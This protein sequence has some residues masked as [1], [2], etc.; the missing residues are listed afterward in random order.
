MEGRSTTRTTL[1]R[2]RPAGWDRAPAVPRHPRPGD[3]PRPRTGLR[4]GRVERPGRRLRR[5]LRIALVVASALV[6]ALTGTAW[7]LYRDVTAGISTTDVI[8]GGGDGGD[9][10]ILLVGVDS[11]TDAHGNPLPPEV[12][13]MLSSGPDTGVLNSDTIILLHVP[14]GG[15]A[16][17]AFSIPR[18]AYV[19]IPG[20]RRDKINAA[21]PATKAL[22]AERLV[23][24]GVKD[25][26]QIETESAQEG[27]STL[28]RTVENLTGQSVDHYAEINLL[29][30]YNLTT[31]IGGVDVCLRDPV[32]DPLSGARFPAGPQTISGTDALAFVRQRHGL[33]EGDLSRIRRQQVFLAAVADKILA[34]GTLSDPARLGTL[35]EVAQ[36]SLVIDA[37]WDL[38]GFA[39]QAADIAAGNLQ[40]VTIP[41]DG[42][43]S[44]ARGDVVLVDPRTVEE[45]IER[46][47]GEQAAAAEAA[48]QAA[49]QAAEARAALPPP[50]PADLI[51]SRYVVD[52]QNGSALGGMAAS[53]ADHLRG[54]GFARGIVDNTEATD[55]SVVRYTGP[56]AE[57]ARVVAEQLG[58][59]ST[60]HDGSVARGHLNVVLGSDFDP[61]VVPA[62]A[63]EPPAPTTNAAPKPTEPVTASGVPCID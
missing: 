17:T 11:R 46:R 58:D 36:Q 20:Y 8:A 19:N 55:T 24:E 32:D 4:P 51:A 21:Y 27:R 39:G 12:Q 35:V 56:D 38:L 50:P 42:R 30:F 25:P 53:V 14:E 52:V 9:L 28:V 59:I 49:A 3:V 54:L 6:M 62:E 29:G 57:A 7:G 5:R 18:D 37:G 2:P 1:T 16:A 13:R 63:S 22:A 15:G 33:P 45:F 41:T 23:A 60:E 34:G 26:Q 44:N 61:A 10:N 47:I 43:D 40:F 48:A 31:A